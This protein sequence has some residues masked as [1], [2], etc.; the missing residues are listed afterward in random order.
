MFTFP[1]TQ[2]SE[3][4]EIFYVA[5]FIYVFCACVFEANLLCLLAV[6]VL[7][8][9]SFFSRTVAEDVGYCIFWVCVGV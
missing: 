1:A 2:K 5:T 3:W 6:I 9:F 8:F 4:F 7:L